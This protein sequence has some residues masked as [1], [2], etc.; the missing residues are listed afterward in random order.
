MTMKNML[1]RIVGLLDVPKGNPDLLKAQYRAL[2]RQ[3]P[4]MYLIL[5]TNTWIVS[6]THWAVAPLWLI[7]WIPL[8]LTLVCGLRLVNWWK[9]RLDK[10]TPELALVALRRVNHLAFIFAFCFTA[11][12]LALLPYGDANMRSHLAFYMAMTMISSIFS[13]VQLRLAALIVTVIVNAAFIL[14]IM[15]MGEPTLIASTINT[16]L[17]SVG[18]LVILSINQRDFARMVNAQ[19]KARRKE[20]A[21]GRLL[22]MIDD[23]PVAVMTVDPK[24]LCIT[25]TNE[26]STN[27]IRKIE[28]LLPINADDLLGTSIDVFHRHPEH[29]RRILA[30]HRNL[31]HNA[32]I[33]VGPEVLDLKV[34]A[35]MSDDGAYIFPMLT[36]ALVTKEVEAENR[37]LQLAH[38]DT[39]T[40][41]PNRT[42]F[43]EEMS[44]ELA[45]PG[46]QMGLFYIDVDGFKLINDTRGHAAGDV[47]L[48]QVSE[49]LRATCN[50][51]GVRIGR[52]GGDEFAALVP[53]SNVN[54]AIALANEIIRVLSAPYDLEYDRSIKFGASVGIALAPEHGDTADTLF[55]RA[56]LALYTAKAAGKGQAQ[57]F[58]R[59]MENRIRERRDLEKDLRAA[60]ENK[61]GLFVFYQPIVDAETGRI[62]AREALV[63]WRHPHKGWVSPAEFIP[64]AEQSG[65]I[66]QIGEFVLDQACRDAMEREDG[67]RVAVN[68]SATQLGKGVIAQTIL[69]ALARSGLSPGRLEIEVTETAI[70]DA[71]TAAI[72]DLRRLRDMGV[73][74]ALDDFGTGY[75]SLSHLR[76]FPFDKIK[77]DR[78][79]VK[80]AV[81]RDESAAVVKAVADLGRRLGV[82]T[83][84]EGVETQEQ[85]ARMREEGCAEIQGYLFGKPEPNARDAPI[86]ARL[87]GDMRRTA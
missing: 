53:Y 78:S 63:R 87:N 16:V 22:R 50:G 23:M 2:S 25:Y 67:A 28:H 37:I 80:E 5:L 45:K 35:V 59:D 24:T 15:T 29:Q 77:I 30:D 70:V 55:A 51:P 76:L 27:L 69:S 83:V 18:M 68:I 43:Y 47:L 7:F 41:L 9:S 17:V 73:R 49:R 31:P 66:D 79:F 75:S 19:T 14:F 81:D 32:R 1:A 42:T 38:Y 40:G 21:Q 10:P 52:L 60:I 4:L 58:T 56:D 74:V 85:L 62:T 54:S 39:L 6:V 61:D 11:W 46:N 33:R 44:S 71:E 12:A 20:E 13:L 64:I 26:T 36:W 48:C 84:A 34:S 3:M 82:T 65:L 72:D 86:I 8:L 57:V